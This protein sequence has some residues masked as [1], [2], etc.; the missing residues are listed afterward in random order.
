MQTKKNRWTTLRRHTGKKGRRQKGYILWGG[1]CSRGRGKGKANWLE[2]PRHK[3]I[4]KHGTPKDIRLVV[5]EPK[6]GRKWHG[7]TVQNLTR[8]RFHKGRKG[9]L[10][11]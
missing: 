5:E 4:G 1:L 10:K 2:R 6:A 8:G 7:F 3:N 9:A 11:K